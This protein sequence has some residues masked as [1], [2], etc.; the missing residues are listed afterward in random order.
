MATGITIQFD[1]T[2]ADAAP[3]NPIQPFESVRFDVGSSTIVGHFSPTQ[4]QFFRT[5]NYEI[6]LSINAVIPDAGG[7]VRFQLYN[8][9]ANPPAPIPSAV[10]VNESGQY[11]PLGGYQP[12]GT[13]QRVTGFVYP[14]IASGT[15]MSVQNI[16]ITLDPSDPSLASTPVPIAIFT[17]EEIDTANH[18]VARLRIT[19]L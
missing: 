14:G 18:V 17:G 19:K 6:S 10:F 13:V 8:H 4:F 5:G 1:E 12:A 3:H 11:T 16:S 7:I 15:I 2:A 9:T